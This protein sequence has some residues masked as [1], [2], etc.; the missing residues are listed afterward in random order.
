LSDGDAIDDVAIYPS[1][2]QLSSYVYY[3]GIGL[4]AIIDIKGQT[5]SFSYDK[6]GRQLAVFD[7]N[8]DVVKAYK[9]NYAKGGF[10]STGVSGT[11]TKN[12]CSGGTGGS[13]VVYSIPP[14]TFV[15]QVSQQDADSQ[16]TAALASGGQAYANANG[17]C[18]IMVQFS[19][20][21]STNP[22]YPGGPN[23]AS[24]F[25]IYF[26]NTNG[27]TL[28][29]FYSN[30]INNGFAVPQGTYNIELSIIGQAYDFQSGKGW[31]SWDITSANGAVGSAPYMSSPYVVN[32][33]NLTGIT[34]ATLNLKGGGSIE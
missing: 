29:T 8:K 7:Q 27:T 11:F 17:G 20:V 9:Y 21:N 3:P 30:T 32:N 18:N 31:G 34:S 25:A 12:N 23:S 19:F 1:D 16:A 24:I 6:L 13:S 4:R 28:Y 5:T 2:A 14:G 26:K 10:Y 15:S 22:D 33:V